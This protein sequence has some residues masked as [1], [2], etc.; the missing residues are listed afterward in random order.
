M[1]F[2]VLFLSTLTFFTLSAQMDNGLVANLKFNGT[3]QD[4]STSQLNTQNNS[5]KFGTDRNGNINEAAEFGISR[6]III[7]DSSNIKVDF[8]I[9]ISV[10]IKINSFALPNVVFKT[11][12]V[13]N[14]YYGYWSN[15]G[16]DGKIAISFG[17]GLGGANSANRRSFIADK[18]LEVGK[19][20]HVVMIIDAHNDMKIYIDCVQSSGSYSGTGSTTMVYSDSSSSIGGDIGNTAWPSGTYLDG[21]LDDLLIFN[22]TLSDFEVKYLCSQKSC[23]NT[24]TLYDTTH[25]TIYDSTKV[26]VQDTLNIYL[27]NVLATVYNESSAKTEVKVYPN[28]AQHN[29]TVE[30]DYPN[31]LSGVTIKLLDAQGNVVHNN[32]VSGAIQTIEV[33]NWSTGVY[34]LHI[35]NGT[36]TVDVRKIIVNN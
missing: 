6:S 2:I 24:V 25:V 3:I 23:T 9:T 4:E 1:K 36:T 27:S 29:I 30:I 17:G 19:W 33:K 5:I 11:D 14:N 18:P 31:N 7:P 26:T 12:D 28:P 16:T 8:P 34:F 21:S 15:I 13:Y 22:R 10:W 32:I 20:H 35:I